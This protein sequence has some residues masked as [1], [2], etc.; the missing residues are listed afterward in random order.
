MVLGAQ[1]FDRFDQVVLA[2]RAATNDTRAEKDSLYQATMYH[3]HKGPRHLLGRERITLLIVG[4]TEYAV[5]AIVFASSGEHAFQQW[6]GLAASHL[7]MEYTEL[8]SGKHAP[9]VDC[10]VFLQD[11]RRDTFFFVSYP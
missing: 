10:A 7:G 4:T 8:G 6:Y 9:I 2:L 5:V 11:D 1:D 3:F